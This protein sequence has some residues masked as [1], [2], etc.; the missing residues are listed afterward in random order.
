MAEHV[1]SD[2]ATPAPS[3]DVARSLTFFF[4]EPGWLPKLLVG[5][6]FAVLSPLIVGT[7]FMVGYA[8]AIARNTR[9]GTGP[10]LPEWEN[11]PELFIDGLKGLAISLA[12]KLPL[13]FLA[14]LLLFA[15]LGGVLL[16][17]EGGS[18]EELFFFG[19]PALFGGFVVVVVLALAV[20]VY[21]PA[22]FVR[23]VRTGRLGDVF[24]VMANIEF[25]RA[26]ASSYVMGL[27]AIVLAA[28]IGQLGFFFFCVGVFPATFWST[29][30]MGYVIGELAKLDDAPADELTTRSL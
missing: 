10:T 29:C 4:E 20:L 15:L 11:F 21:V 26:H 22:A 23:F 9:A 14:F 8:I 5:S 3:F 25:I 30:V 13:A 16:G 17:R 7:V 12:H 19:I 27:L 24:D 2:A 18:S 28:L 6:L 1:A